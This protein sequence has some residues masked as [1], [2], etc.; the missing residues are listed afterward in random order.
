MICNSVS[1]D[2]SEV[3]ASRFLAAAAVCVMLLSFA[4]ERRKSY[5]SGRIKVAME[6]FLQIFFRF[7]ALALG[8]FLLNCL[9]KTASKS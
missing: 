2:G 6:F 5:W 3:V 9:V 4:A 7:G 1:V 8:S